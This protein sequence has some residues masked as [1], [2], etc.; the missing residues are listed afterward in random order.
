MKLY[1]QSNDAKLTLTFG[2]LQNLFKVFKMQGI[3]NY[4]R[5]FPA[6]LKMQLAKAMDRFLK[7][8]VQKWA[9]PSKDK[10][11]R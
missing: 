11:N 2:N 5:S 8:M 6:Y 3:A 9:S 1:G 4:A 10:S 7:A